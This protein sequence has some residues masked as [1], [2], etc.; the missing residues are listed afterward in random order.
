[1]DEKPR[2]DWLASLASRTAATLARCIR[3]EEAYVRAA[4]I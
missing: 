2:L 1:M 4:G 3:L